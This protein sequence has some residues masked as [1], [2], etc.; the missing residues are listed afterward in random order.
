MHNSSVLVPLSDDRDVYLVLDDF[1]SALADSYL[2]FIGP[3][4]RDVT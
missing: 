4:L 2:P 1:A 3:R